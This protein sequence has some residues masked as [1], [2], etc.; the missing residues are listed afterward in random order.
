MDFEFR[1]AA[2][3]M[4]LIKVDRGVIEA[5]CLRTL[6]HE[7]NVVPLY[8]CTYTWRVQFSFHEYCFAREVFEKRLNFEKHNSL[9]AFL[10]LFTRKFQIFAIIRN[11]NSF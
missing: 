5:A 10:F 11:V 7:N 2:S 1:G 4:A 3:I 9:L 6:V 8:G